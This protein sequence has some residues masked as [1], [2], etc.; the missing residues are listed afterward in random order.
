MTLLKAKLIAKKVWLAAKKFW[1]VVILG[2]LLIC[3]A[4]ISALTRNGA[5]LIGALDLLDA[6]RESHKA[7]SFGI[8]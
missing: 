7:E 5:L 6:K 4:L 8:K 1:W 3:A 2:L